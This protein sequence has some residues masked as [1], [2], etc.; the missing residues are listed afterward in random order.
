[1]FLPDQIFFLGQNYFGP[2]LFFSQ[3]KIPN[4]AN[5]ILGS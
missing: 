5:Y 3:T 4:S 2:K 1:M